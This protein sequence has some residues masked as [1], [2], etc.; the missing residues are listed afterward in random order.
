MSL[1]TSCVSLTETASLG[2]VS[3]SQRAA[4]Y[5]QPLFVVL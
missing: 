4:F 5:V 1:G 2:E 3:I